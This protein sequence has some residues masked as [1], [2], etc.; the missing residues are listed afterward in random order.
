MKLRTGLTLAAIAACAANSHAVFFAVN[1]L[2]G[3]SGTGTTNYSTGGNFATAGGVSSGLLKDYATNTNTSVTLSVS[4]PAGYG[5]AQWDSG[6]SNGGMSASGTDAYNLF[7][8]KL[9]A[10][11]Y[12]WYNDLTNSRTRLT[13]TG[14]SPSA[15]YTFALFGNRNNAGYTDRFTITELVGA[16][17]FTNTSSVG[18]TQ[19]GALT[20]V[21]TGANTANGYL[22][23]YS[24]ISAGADG[25]FYVDVYGA[26]G[27]SNS[28]KW[29]ANGLA[30]TEAVPEPATLG[31]LALAGIALVR[32][33]RQG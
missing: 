21:V 4:T 32:R 11:G 1:D 5:D 30:L 17:S 2:G 6:T 31:S 29:Y 13:F 33:R 10:L 22:A 12:L 7:N 16:D 8:G 9:N 24:D 15:T 18:T 23:Q 19:S 27:G 26:V 3:S 25:T 20:T 28:H 14:L